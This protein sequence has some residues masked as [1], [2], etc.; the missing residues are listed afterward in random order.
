MDDVKDCLEATGAEG[1]LSAETLLENPALFVGFRTAERVSGC[2][3]DFVDG[4]LDQANLL[5]EYLNLCEKYLV[6]W[7]IIRSHV[8]K[9]LGDWFS[10]QLHIRE[11]FKKQCKITFE[12]LYDM[13][14]QLRA[15]GTRMLLY[16][17]CTETEPIDT[18]QY[19]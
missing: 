16:L 9:L 14:D 10:L 8:H 4:K 17:K 12:Y 18:D 5:I 19:S 13:V 15:T 7:R 3:G 2:E 6:P 1:V 11:D